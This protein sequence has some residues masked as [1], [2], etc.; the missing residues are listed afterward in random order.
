MQHAKS[1]YFAELCDIGCPCYTPNTPIHLNDI[2]ENW[3]HPLPPSNLSFLFPLLSLPNELLAHILNFTSPPTFFSLISTCK[4]LYSIGGSMHF[5][6]YHNKR[7]KQKRYLVCTSEDIA[8]RIAAVYSII[9]SICARAPEF[10]HPLH[11]CHN[12]SI[13]ASRTKD[14]SKSGTFPSTY[15]PRAWLSV[16]RLNV[17][18]GTAQQSIWEAIGL[19]IHSL[20]AHH[21]RTE[22]QRA[23][24]DRKRQGSKEFK[25]RARELAKKHERVHQEELRASKSR[26]DFYLQAHQKTILPTTTVPLAFQLALWT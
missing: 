1:H 25:A 11:T 9:N 18:P 4:R 3:N 14:L 12:E 19:P 8:H 24:T 7:Q 2:S 6:S 13:N 17:G 15:E 16:H 5:S 23:I 20:Q 21:W 26:G 10:V 22:D